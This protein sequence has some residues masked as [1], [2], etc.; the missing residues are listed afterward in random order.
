MRQ[1]RDIGRLHPLQDTRA[2]EFDRLLDDAKIVRDLLAS[3]AGGDGRQYFALA[4]REPGET[5]PQRLGIASALRS[6]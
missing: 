6:D 1:F 3:P 4:W 5:L 2:M